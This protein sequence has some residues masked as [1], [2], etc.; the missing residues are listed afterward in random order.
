MKCH[1]VSFD[2]MVPA[3]RVIFVGWFN[4]K[5]LPGHFAPWEGVG[6]QST[7]RKSLLHSPKKRCPKT[8]SEAIRTSRCS[9]NKRVSWRLHYRAQRLVFASMDSGW[10]VAYKIPTRQTIMQWIKNVLK[11]PQH[12]TMTTFGQESP[13]L[14]TPNSCLFSPFISPLHTSSLQQ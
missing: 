14:N 13:F 5:V 9:G 7:W 2:V 10:K 3:S 1:L 12:H 4:R 11:P 6:S 8:K